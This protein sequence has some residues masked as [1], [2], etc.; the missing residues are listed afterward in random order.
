MFFHIILVLYNQKISNKIFS[1]INNIYICD[2]S[3]DSEIK[4]CNRKYCNEHN[5]TYVD[6]NGNAGLPKAYN[7]AVSQIEKNPQNYILILDQDT[8]LAPDFLEK[9]EA[10]IKNNSDKKIFVPVIKDSAGIM[11][12][13]QKKGL[14]FVHSKLVDFNKD[15]SN[16]SF[17]NSGMCINSMLFE[18]VSYDEN[19]FL[20]MVDHDFVETV[21]KHFG[22][23]VFYV[24]Q[25]LEIFQNFSGVTKNSRQSDLVRFKILVKDQTY[26]YKKNYDD[27]VYNKRKLF[28]RALK[29]SVQHRTMAFYKLLGGE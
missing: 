18:S 23:E 26:F 2:N 3:T 9:Y 10:A 4:S 20:D 14:G 1:N 28:M 22:N 19:L 15:I 24:I 25:D 16:Y 11:S 27:T 8:E 6:M 13:S 21:R 17:I 7:K 5:F 29:L 12:P